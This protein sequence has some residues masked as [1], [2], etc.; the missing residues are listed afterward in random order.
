MIYRGRVEYRLD[1][2]KIGRVKVRVPGL[3]GK[4]AISSLPW[5]YCLSHGGGFDS[6]T[7]S[8]PEV[9]AW[10]IVEKADDGLFYILGVVR[11][12]GIEDERG[13]LIPSSDQNYNKQLIG[14][15]KNDGSLE[16][17]KEAQNN[18]LEPDISIINKSLKGSTIMISDRNTD[19]YLSL[20]APDGSTFKMITPKKANQVNGRGNTRLEHDMNNPDDLSK[21]DAT[22]M[23]IKDSSGNILR[24]MGNKSG[25]KRTIEIVSQTGDNYS[26]LEISLDDD[27]LTL[28]TKN[29]GNRSELKITS[30]SIAGT[31]NNSSFKLEN[32][33]FDINCTNF[34]VNATNINISGNNTNIKTDSGNV[35]GDTLN[36]GGSNVSIGPTVALGSSVSKQGLTSPNPEG[37][38]SWDNSIDGKYGG[39]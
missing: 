38:G 8:I 27:N 15:W 5:A 6:G 26:G 18:N 39:D 14:T 9:G 11:G 19:E 23:L 35:T 25:G 4:I 22:A 20:I 13:S 3:H 30:N 10:V 32:D 16:T 33:S 17:P 29:G 2:Q 34:T 28:F 7:F 36:I 31:T 12:V 21:Y 1:P 37:V 24:L